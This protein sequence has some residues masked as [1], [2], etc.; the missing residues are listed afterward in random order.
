MSDILLTQEDYARLKAVVVEAYALRD[1]LDQVR[2]T[3]MRITPFHIEMPGLRH[4]L[5]EALNVDLDNPRIDNKVA[6]N[7]SV[8]PH[9]VNPPEY[10][11]PMLEAIKDN[12]ARLHAVPEKK[13]K[14]RAPA[15]RRR[16]SATKK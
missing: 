9:F 14:P 7:V 10:C 13:A 12:I 4:A 6:V 8:N 2:K 16:N 5:N 11:D 3:A 1:Y 15:N